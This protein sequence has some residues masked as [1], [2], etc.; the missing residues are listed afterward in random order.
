MNKKLSLVL[1]TI[2]RAGQLIIERLLGFLSNEISLELVITRETRSYDHK[3]NPVVNICEKA[4]IRCI[5]PDFASSKYLD[6]VKNIN[7][8]FIII[9]NFHKIIRNDLIKL[10]KIGTFNLHSSILPKMRGGTSIIWALK[11]ELLKTGVTLHC[12]T[13]GIDDGDIV[14]QKEVFIDFLD[15]QQSLYEKITIAKFELLNRFLVKNL[16]GEKIIA[17]PQNHEDATYLPKR[18]DSDGLIDLNSNLRDI[19]NHIRSF[20]PWTGAYLEI[21][22]IKIRLRQV[23]PVKKRLSSRI[24]NSYL[25]LG[26]SCNSGVQTII[27]HS[28][29]D[30]IER[31]KEFNKELSQKIFNFWVNNIDNE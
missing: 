15:T 18:K 21:D 6:I 10:S 27:I 8:D 2:D 1:L 23:I 29:T 28:V 11:N 20:D 13:E 30:V 9:C 14:D 4:G 22:N 5:Q 7:P 12:V 24:S 3:G 17:E 26:K 16:N 25:I 31:P 19:Y